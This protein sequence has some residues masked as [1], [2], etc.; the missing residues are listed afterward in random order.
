[1]LQHNIMFA[2]DLRVPD[3]KGLLSK[4]TPGINIDRA[5]QDPASSTKSKDGEKDEPDKN[6]KNISAE[7]SAFLRGID[8]ADKGRME[9]PYF[10]LS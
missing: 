8:E 2:L 5:G 10:F 7:L 9:V 1:M 3:E 4:R 6:N